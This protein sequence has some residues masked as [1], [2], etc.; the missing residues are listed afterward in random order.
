MKVSWGDKIPNILKV[1][2]FMFQTTN[3]IPNDEVTK[4][5]KNSLLGHVD[6]PDSAHG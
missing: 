4:F 5:S 3:Q 2:K 1:I 6:T